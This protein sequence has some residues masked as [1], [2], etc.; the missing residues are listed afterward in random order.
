[1]NQE[2]T[3]GR[4][5]PSQFRPAWWLP[6][7]HAQTLW[8]SLA[9][10]RLSPTHRRRRVELADGDF[11]DLA[12]G[13]AEGAR[14]LLIHGLEGSLGSH[15]AGGLFLALERAGF[16]P[17]FMYLR[18]C[19]PE[20]NRLERAY[21]SGA[22]HDLAEV[23]GALRDDPEGPPIAAIGFS[24]GANLLLKYLGETRAPLVGLGIAV[25]VPFVLRDAMLRLDL[26]LSRLYRGYLLR[27]LKANI[28][29]KRACRPVA[30]GVDLD[31]IRDFNAFDER[32]TAPLNG[33]AGVF[34]YYERASCRAY[35]PRIHTP[36]HIIQ[37]ADDPFVFPSTLPWEQE[38]GPGVTLEIAAAG[39]HVGFVAGRWPGRPVYWLES[40]LLEL[41]AGRP[42]AQAA[43]LGGAAAQ[44]A[45][46]TAPSAVPTSP[47]AR[48]RRTA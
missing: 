19:S 11:I 13:T 8:P 16:Q 47:R 2:S 23:L 1:M 41:L 26:G 43:G 7:P 46:V 18:G 34:D 14:V 3:L 20:P 12:V 36:T 30:P 33:F 15:Y 42:A 9:R 44:A 29:R 37:A 45:P 31:E 39:G 21:H 40:R 17:V 27:K 38:L 35:L 28:R 22:T 48:S 25:S 5:L 4:I 24:L 6:G 10:P 32:I